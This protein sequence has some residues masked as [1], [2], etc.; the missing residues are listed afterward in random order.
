MG[1]CGVCEK[2]IEDGHVEN[3]PLAPAVK[4][5]EPYL[6]SDIDL[7]Y[8]NPATDIV[9]SLCSLNQTALSSAEKSRLQRL[10]HQ[11]TSAIRTVADALRQK[12]FFTLATNADDLL[13]EYVTLDGK[14]PRD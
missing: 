12:A 7:G 2:N 11:H 6:D 13:Y 14:P 1:Q 3:C 10:V 9:L 8:L 5:M 4:A